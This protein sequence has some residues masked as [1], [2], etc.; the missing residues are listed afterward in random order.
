MTDDFSNPGQRGLQAWFDAWRSCT[1]D[2]LSQVSGQ[3]NSFEIVLEPLA[4]GDSDLRYTMAAAGAVQGEMALRFSEAAGLRLARKFL[5][6]GETSAADTSPDKGI[7]GEN[8]EALEELLR[9]IGGLAATTVGEFAGGSIQFQLSRAEAPWAWTSD[10]VA[11]IRTRNGAGTEIALEIR[12][13]PALVAALAARAEVQAASS[14]PSASPTSSG[15]QGAGATASSPPAAMPVS[16]QVP[17]SSAG[18]RRLLD[19]GLGVK[20][21]FGTRRMLLRDVLAL[22][23][24]HVV[25]LENELNSPVDLLLDGRII[26]R[27]EVVVID[28]KYGLRVTDVVNPAPSAI[29][30]AEP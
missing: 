6:E 28:G 16:E 9:Q 25:E 30:P 29:C 24:G 13:S 2:V 3:P 15:A 27:G 8:R 11:T 4:A 18:Y 22:S 26:A 1:Q 23:A 20:L 7:S 21:R 19:V 17:V 10:H 12:L 5:G 14:L